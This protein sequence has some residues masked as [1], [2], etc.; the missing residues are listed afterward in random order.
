MEKEAT[1]LFLR[2]FPPQPFS[3]PSTPKCTLTD[4]HTPLRY[5]D[6]V[7]IIIIVL[8]MINLQ[9]VYKSVIMS[10]KKGFFETDFCSKVHLEYRSF[11][12]PLFDLKTSLASIVN[13]NQLL[14]VAAITNSKTLRQNLMNFL[15]E[16]SRVVNLQV[17]SPGSK[18]KK[19]TSVQCFKNAVNQ[20][21]TCRT[22]MGRS[23]I[24]QTSM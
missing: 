10:L 9:V 21:E 2:C 16:F 23:S 6:L 17:R 14:C 13:S 20:Q 15:H 11:K 7:P 22:Y 5:R 18:A 8:F 24:M 19:V 12:K 3:I 4:P 1:K